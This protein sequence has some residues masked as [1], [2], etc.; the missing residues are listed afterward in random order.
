MTIG[1]S[2]MFWGLLAG[3][4][5]FSRKEQGDLLR[6]MSTWLYKKLSISQIL[7]VYMRRQSRQVQQTLVCLHPG[8][9]PAQLL[10]E[11]YIGK[12]RIVL[13]ILAAGSLLACG[14]ELAKDTSRVQVVQGIV[15]R[16]EEEQ[17]IMLEVSVGEDT[18]SVR[19]EITLEIG[20]RELRAEEAEALYGQFAELLDDLILGENESLQEVRGSLNLPYEVEGY[21]FTVNWS[22]SNTALLGTEGEVHIDNLESP[23]E[24]VL[25]A[26]VLY[27]E[28]EWQRSWEVMLQP[29]LRTAREQ[30]LYNLARQS[31]KAA[32]DG[33]YEESFALPQVIDGKNVTW[34]KKE[35]SSGMTILLL[36]LAAAAVVYCMKDRDLR[37]DLVKRRM[38]IK[39]EYPVLVSKYALFL[40]AGVTVRG[41]F[42]KI[43]R[44]YFEK[45]KDGGSDPHPLY[46]EMLY[47]CNELQA[48]ISESKVYE[49]FGR[50]TGVQE[51]TR[52]C[53]LLNQN[54][55]K[56][57]TALVHRLKEEYE[58]AVKE[59]VQAR[60]RQGEEAGTKLL[61]PM[62]M[63]LLMVLLMIMLPAFSGLGI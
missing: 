9:S 3:I 19:G 55:K 50:R 48:G 6:R 20:E 37:D 52:L 33:R 44:N 57:N 27:R 14:A 18:E 29:P 45:E 63:M 17:T 16:G 23:A 22:S 39:Q 26:E 4:A 53:T 24:V 59:S 2:M 32:V 38:R 5:L 49:N 51:Y 31:E 43:C 58:E 21:P 28:L 13:L 25:R 10:M 56:G 11:Y 60:K 54:L 12:I 40:G 34:K 15:S 35:E 8:E 7:Q 46:E 41:A 62:V 1:L 47:S 61:V 42:L 30:L 36:T